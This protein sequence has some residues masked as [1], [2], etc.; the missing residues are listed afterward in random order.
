MRP[1]G[2]GRG[3]G[4]DPWL[5]RSPLLDD[6]ESVDDLESLVARNVQRK[7]LHVTAANRL[8][9]GSKR[10]AGNRYCEACE[11]EVEFLAAVADMCLQV[12]LGAGDTAKQVGLASAH[13]HDHPKVPPS[14]DSDIV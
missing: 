11:R 4:A 13:S 14:R 2:L 12:G 8:D 10:R 3:V 9:C 7:A 5:R 6:P 1:R